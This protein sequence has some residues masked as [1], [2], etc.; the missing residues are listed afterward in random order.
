MP[1]SPDTVYGFN[2]VCRVGPDGDVN[3]I[4][5]VDLSYGTSPNSG[6]L[7][8]YDVICMNPDG[9]AIYCNITLSYGIRFSGHILRLLCVAREAGW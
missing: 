8:E 7:R 6:S 9:F 4:T 3:Y 2:G 5:Y 1:K